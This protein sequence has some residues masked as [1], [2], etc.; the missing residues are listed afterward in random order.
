MCGHASERH[1]AP[2]Q[3]AGAPPPPIE[4]GVRIQ[5][6]GAEHGLSADR[7]APALRPSEVAPP[8]A[9]TRAAP[10][11]RPAVIIPAPAS[12]RA[13]DPGGA[14]YRKLR[15]ILV[16]VAVVAALVVGL[17][18]LGL[19]LTGDDSPR[20]ASRSSEPAPPVDPDAV[21]KVIDGTTFRLGSGE[22]IKL[23][24]IDSPKVPTGDCYSAE[25]VA[26]LSEL[27]P[28]GTKVVLRPEPKLGKKDKFGRRLAQVF[29]GP[30]HVNLEMVRRGAAAPYF[31]FGRRGRFAD[32]LL[33]AGRL[34]RR[35]D[36]GLWGACPGTALD[37][38]HQVH[39]T[40]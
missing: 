3:A 30:T 35:A 23:A 34:A 28:A 39:T 17:A 26:A 25:A 5:S 12:L 16:A 4:Y 2:A 8:D 9:P 1:P 7:E 24:Q 38:V 37:P 10:Q 14:R 40:S 6:R 13:D 19:L 11:E 27:L 29:V 36:R 20:R 32:E 31:F 22:R 15:L 21:E 33:Q 18:G